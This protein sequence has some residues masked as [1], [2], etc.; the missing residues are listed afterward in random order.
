M[1]IVRLEKPCELPVKGLVNREE[2]LGVSADGRQLD[3][4]GSGG[5]LVVSDLDDL[6][7]LEKIKSP[8]KCLEK[9]LQDTV[10]TEQNISR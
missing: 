7:W 8:V 6:I 1:T 9:N 2:I 10:V 4:I 3:L 5:K